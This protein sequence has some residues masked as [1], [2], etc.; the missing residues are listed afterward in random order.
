MVSVATT[1]DELVVLIKEWVSRENE[2]KQLQKTIRERRKEMKDL[3]KSLMDTMK[4]N[5]VDCFDI[6][7]GKILYKQSK[8]KKAITKEYLM[9]VLLQ[10]YQDGD[11]AKQIVD[12]ILNSREEVMRETIRMKLNKKV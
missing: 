4:E 3:T 9:S 1:K 10:H 6:N 7:D 5:E 11:Q 2:I 8:T 12:M